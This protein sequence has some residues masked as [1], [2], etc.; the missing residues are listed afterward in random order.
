MR[1]IPLVALR[2]ALLPAALLLA[3][4]LLAEPAL[5]MTCSQWE[6]LGPQQKAAAV[7]QMIQSAVSGS[8]G[9]SYKVDRGA[10]TRCLRAS[11][12]DIEYEFDGVCSDSRTA[13]MNAIRTTFKDFI[14]GCAN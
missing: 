3:A 7:E 1:A 11:S 14:W 9:R 5:A 8:G 4:L 6:G 2:A 10:M 13:G 12:R